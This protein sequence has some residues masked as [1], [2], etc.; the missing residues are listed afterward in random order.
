MSLLCKYYR[1]E[2]ITSIISIILLEKA[3]DAWKG[4]MLL[5]DLMPGTDPHKD[6]SILRCTV[7]DGARREGDASEGDWLLFQKA[8]TEV[9]GMWEDLLMRARWLSVLMRWLSVL[10]LTIGG[11]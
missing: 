3:I 6:N 11:S 8:L 9:Q 5:V 4:L 2:S 1:N 7:R 10:M